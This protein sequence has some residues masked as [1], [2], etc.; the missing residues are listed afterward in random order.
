MSEAALTVNLRGLRFGRVPRH[1]WTRSGLRLSFVGR[2][3]N[4][5]RPGSDDLPA[6]IGALAWR[7]HEPASLRVVT[8]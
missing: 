5:V 8:T 6:T 1:L 2:K 3:L 4:A 7:E